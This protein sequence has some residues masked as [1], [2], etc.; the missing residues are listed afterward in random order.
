MTPQE[1]AKQCL[2][3]KKSI[4]RLCNEADNDD[5]IIN[6][7][8]G[9]ITDVLSE[10]GFSPL[11]VLRICHTYISMMSSDFSQCD[12]DSYMSKVSEK[13]SSKKR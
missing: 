8:L 11:E 12:M 1:M 2:D 3:L 9:S 5:I 4:L 10:K 6:A 7:I 13:K